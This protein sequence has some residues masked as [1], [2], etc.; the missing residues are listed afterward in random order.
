MRTTRD[1]M[2]MEVAHAIAKRGTCSRLQVGAVFSRD[3]RIVSTGY[4]GAP[5]GMP[6][7]THEEYVWHEP[8]TLGEM[9]EW[10]LTFLQGSSEFT[11]AYMPP[12]IGT[13]FS[14]NGSSVVVTHTPNGKTPLS[15]GCEVAEHAERNAIAWAARHGLALEG[16]EV[17]VTHMPCLACARTLINAG[18]TRLTYAQPYRLTAGVELLEAAKVEVFEYLPL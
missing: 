4:N 7:C 17:H 12:H 9:P 1:E 11:D 3:G 13:R 6:H 5:A 15:Q 14:Y 10:L 18:V 8:Y 16:T 2:L